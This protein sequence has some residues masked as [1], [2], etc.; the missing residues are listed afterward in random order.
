MTSL[1]TLKARL[2]EVDDLGN[3]AALLRWDQTT[4]MPPEGAPARGRQLATLSRLSHERFTDAET[5]R[6]LDAA[7]RETASLPFE[8]DEASLVRVTRRAWEQAVKLPS[9]LVAELQEHSARSYQAWT[10]ARPRNDFA[11]MRPHL[12]RTLE[13]SRRMA[14]CFPGYQ[15]IADPLIDFSDYGMKAETVKRLFAD[16]RARLVPI[17][18]AVTSRPAADDACIRQHAPEADQ[19]AFGLEV[20]RRFGFDFA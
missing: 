18:R 3:A 11:A 13:L 14:D 1:D 8:S 6:L 2:L 15:H 20:I 16:L 4:Y 19:L 9:A 12:E 17:V 10:E 7:A 5:G